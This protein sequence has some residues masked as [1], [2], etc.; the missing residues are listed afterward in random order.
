MQVLIQDACIHNTMCTRSRKHGQLI[1]S[2]R[3]WKYVVH[4]KYE[5]NIGKTLPRIGCLMSNVYFLPFINDLEVHTPFN[6]VNC[7]PDRSEN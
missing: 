4:R 2:C 5:D 3:S 1:S 7:E 6:I